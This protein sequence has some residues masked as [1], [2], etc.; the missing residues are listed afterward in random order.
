MYEISK[1][2]PAKEFGIAYCFAYHVS[3]LLS[4]EL[5]PTIIVN[6]M[7]WFPCKDG[8]PYFVS[9][10][11]NWTYFSYFVSGCPFRHFDTDFLKQRIASNGVSKDG[12]ETVSY[13]YS[14]EDSLNPNSI[15]VFFFTL[16]QSFPE[17]NLL[18]LFSDGLLISTI[19]D[20][21]CEF[22]SF[23]NLCNHMT[24]G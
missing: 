5:L 24:E 18:I 21:T 9:L 1:F 15:S 23:L 22:F 7:F 10:S 4:W 11:I 13:G 20:L 19:S 14:V 12:I 16:Y 3:W 17:I 2:S 8:S 6:M